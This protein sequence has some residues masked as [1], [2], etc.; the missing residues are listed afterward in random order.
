MRIIKRGALVEFWERHPDSE[1]ALLHWY[2]LTK[3]AQWTNLEDT[4]KTFPHADAIR[5]PSGRSIT[6]FNVGGNKYRLICAIHYNHQKVYILR[7][8]THQDYSRG[9]WRDSL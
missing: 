3:A 5:V 1:G 2:G 8:L 9:S 4:R 7:I 6:V